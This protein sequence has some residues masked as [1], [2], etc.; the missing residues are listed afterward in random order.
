MLHELKIL[1]EHF[2]AITRGKKRF[3][4]RKNDRGFQPGDILHLRE[5][6]AIY[7]GQD[8]IVRVVFMSDFHQ[9]DGFVVMGISDPL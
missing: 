4:I 6:G 1:P 3:E 8:C 5:H 7:T 9:T 2:I